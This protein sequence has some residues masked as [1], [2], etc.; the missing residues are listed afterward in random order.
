MK[1]TLRRLKT[2]ISRGRIKNGLSEEIR[3]HIDQQTEKNIRAGMNPEEARRAAMVRFGGIEQIKESTRD[4][5]RPALLEDFARD[6]R[7][8]TRVLL[9]APGFALVSI[10]TLGLGIGAATAAFS[11]VDG[12]LLRPLPYPDPDRIVRLFQL[13][14]EG[15]RMNVSEPNFLDW[16][17]GTRSFRAMAEVQ[18]YP[19]PVAPVI[20][21]APAAAERINTGGAAVSREFF[22]VMGVRP[23]IGRLFQDN[24]LRVNATPVAIIG[25]QLWVTRFHSASLD[26][27]ALRIDDQVYQVVGIM[28]PG[29]DFPSA[30]QY[31]FPRELLPPQTSR[32]AHNFQVIARIADGVSLETAQSDLSSLRGR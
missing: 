9:R 10:L 20:P 28:P 13:G 2:L 3:F 23:A 21:D 14:S 27:L 22:D 30:S 7:Y 12:V 18:S 16:K 24:E 8:G 6:L 26:R 19:R 15:R 4:E 11:V 25:H 31:W 32:T 29:F 17:S 5:F 1:Q